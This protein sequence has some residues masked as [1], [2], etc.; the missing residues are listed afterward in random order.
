MLIITAEPLLAAS[1]LVLP[2]G[3]SHLEQIT[4]I[5]ISFKE[6]KTL[7][8]LVYPLTL[9]FLWENEICSLGSSPTTIDLQSGYLSKILIIALPNKSYP[10]AELSFPINE[11]IFFFFLKFTGTFDVD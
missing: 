2:N 1:R 3:S 10:F 8:C 11:I 9:R 6:F 4:E 5:L 7:S